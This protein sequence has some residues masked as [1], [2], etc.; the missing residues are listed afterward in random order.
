M[1]LLAITHI[2]KYKWIYII[3][4]FACFAI[5]YITYKSIPK[6]YSSVAYVFATN[7]YSPTKVLTEPNAGSQ[8]DALRFG[9]KESIEQTL[10]LFLSNDIKLNLIEKYDLAAYWDVKKS[11][12]YKLLEKWDQDVKVNITG[13]VSIKIQAYNTDAKLACNIVNDIISY[14]DS[15]KLVMNKKTVQS[16]L[17]ILQTRLTSELSLVLNHTVKPNEIDS[18]FSHTRFNVLEKLNK[19]DSKRLLEIYYK[20]QDAKINL[21]KSFPASFT[22]SKPIENSGEQRPRFIILLIFI[23]LST[24]VLEFFI[25]TTRENINN[26]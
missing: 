13:L 16:T 19:N 10:Q 14:A 8:D 21:D 12:T 3:T 6:E 17:D 23:T 5:S 2:L 7:S 1:N 22:I 9:D 26:K 24:L 25:I 11:E 20:Y 18:A 15:L 4:L